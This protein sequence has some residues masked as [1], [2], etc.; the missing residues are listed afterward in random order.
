MMHGSPSHAG[1]TV[2]LRGG[3][4]S[5]APWVAR[6]ARAGVGHARLGRD[7]RQREGGGGSGGA[8][9]GSGWAGRQQLGGAE[10]LRR[11]RPLVARVRAPARVVGW[12]LEVGRVG[13]QAGR[14][15]VRV[16]AVARVVKGGGEADVP[17]GGVAE[18]PVVRELVLPDVVAEG[19]V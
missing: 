16:E 13:G 8:G 2:P 4:A 3:L 14:V 10:R 7:G 6:D 12:A 1:P 5:G 9:A 19:L 18:G 15:G 17:V 11:Q